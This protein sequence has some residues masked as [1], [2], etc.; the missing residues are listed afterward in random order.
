MRLENWAVCRA[1]GQSPYSAPET[2]VQVLSGK[3]YDHPHFDDGDEI[4]TS[5][6][7][8]IRDGKVLTQSGSLYE[9]GEPAPGYEAAFPGAKARV[10][11]NRQV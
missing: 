3:V 1:T 6:I 11:S 5:G 10:L 4:T 7:V 2:V 9:L 8:G